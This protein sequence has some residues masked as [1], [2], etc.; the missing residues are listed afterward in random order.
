MPNR[1]NPRKASTSNIRD[2]V[3]VVAVWCGG[4]AL[5]LLAEAWTARLPADDFTRT[6]LWSGPAVAQPVGSTPEG[7]PRPTPEGVPSP[8]FQDSKNGRRP[9][10]LS[11]RPCAA[12]RLG[13]DR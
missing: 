11:P 13:R 7:V 1:A 5:A 12:V 9:S 4:A 8:L 3:D 2:G 6:T 10:A